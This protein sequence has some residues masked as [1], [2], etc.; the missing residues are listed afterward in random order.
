MQPNDGALPNELLLRASRAYERGRIRWALRHSVWVALLPLVAFALGG[1]LIGSLILGSVLVSAFAT[2]L[3][4]GRDFGRG[5]WSGL[6]AGIPALLFPL[7]AQLAGHVC[8]PSGCWSL[9]LPACIAG[10]L[11]AGV[12]VARASRR[13]PSPAI[14]LS[15]AAGVAFLTGALGCSCVGYSGVAGLAVGMASSTS[16]SLL[17]WKHRPGA[18]K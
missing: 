2:L 12:L 8:T 10:G 18:T 13:A 15:C 5:A 11:V 4:T 17:A 6:V 7:C 1:R 3:W 16:V 14:A 9:C